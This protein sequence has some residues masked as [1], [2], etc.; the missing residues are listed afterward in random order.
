MIVL[1]LQFKIPYPESFQSWCCI[2]TYST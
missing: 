2:N 1:L